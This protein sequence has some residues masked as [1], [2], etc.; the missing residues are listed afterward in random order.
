LEDG[1]GL[2]GRIEILSEEVPENLGPKEGLD[3][4]GDLI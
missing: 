3:C 1:K 4:S 2:D